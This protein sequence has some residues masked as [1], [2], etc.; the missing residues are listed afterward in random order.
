MGFFFYFKFIQRNKIIFK[1]IEQSHE[2]RSQEQKEQMSKFPE[3]DLTA[4]ERTFSFLALV[5]QRNFPI[6]KTSKST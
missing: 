2:L 5:K 1:K 3:A 6:S 4:E